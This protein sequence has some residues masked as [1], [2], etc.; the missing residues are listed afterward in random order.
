MKWALAAGL[1]ALVL[2]CSYYNGM[3]HADHLAG[4][5]RKAERDGRA[6]EAKGLWGQV[7]V[8]AESALVHH[9]RAGWAPRA[10]LL[11][12]TAQ[13]R[14]GDCANALPVL[15]SVM[16]AADPAV[17]EPAA[18]EAGNCRL[19]LDD[20]LGASDAFGHLLESRHPAWR[21][22]ALYQHGRALRLGGRFNEALEELTRT[23]HPGARGERAAALAGLGRLEESATLIDSL[24]S[25][26]DSLA[27]WEAILEQVDAHDPAVASYLTDRIVQ[28]GTLP[29]TL[30]ARL[31]IADGLRAIQRDTIQADARLAQADSLSLRTPVQAEVVLARVRRLLE[32]AD[33]TS[34]VELVLTQLESLADIPGASEARRQG[35]RLDAAA[36]K[37]AALV[38]DV[39]RDTVAGD[40][41]LFLAAELSRDSLGAA[42]LAARLLTRLRV[43]WPDS[44][45]APKAM[46]ALISLEPLQAD[47]LRAALIRD[48][49]ASP[50]V[51]LVTEGDGAGYQVLEDSL[52]RYAERRMPAGRPTRATSRPRARD[53]DVAPGARPAPAPTPAPPPPPRT[54]VDQ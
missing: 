52:R 27:P 22:L 49:S 11:R 21:E 17:A 28:A 9:P 53:Q 46:L 1:A 16:A 14:L 43:E 48:Y 5:A 33:S 3:Y 36:R 26:A 30:L 2:G 44:P 24:L 42:R 25:A 23:P 7:S 54:P 29:K 4:R 40:V 13:S 39:T 38:S 32:L 31:L 12:G 37:V 45:Y 18:L 35:S 15:E 51:G 47:S 34:V 19:A 20:P 41:R 10:R 50:Y 8:K 6:S